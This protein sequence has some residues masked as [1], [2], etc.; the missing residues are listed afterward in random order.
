MRINVSFTCHQL[1]SKSYFCSN[2]LEDHLTFKPLTGLYVLKITIVPTSR[3][4]ARAVKASD[5]L[6]LAM[7][8]IPDQVRESWYASG[9]CI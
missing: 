6:S 1:H 9:H 2:H 7:G 3:R 8:S 5:S 4:G